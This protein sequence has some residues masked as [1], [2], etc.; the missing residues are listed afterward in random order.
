MIGLLGQIGSLFNICIKCF[1]RPKCKKYIHCVLVSHCVICFSSFLVKMVHCF[2]EKVA[3][4]DET[5][6]VEDSSL[7]HILP[8]IFLVC[9][10]LKANS[11]TIFKDDVILEQTQ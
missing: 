11:Q 2:V 5:K 7:S 9:Q 6:N 4:Q 10:W 8:S 1:R 3:Y